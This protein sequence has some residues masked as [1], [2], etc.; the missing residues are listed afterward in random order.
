LAEIDLRHGRD[1]EAWPNF[2]WR[3]GATPEELPRHLAMIAPDDRP[4]SW[5][6]GKIRRRRL[7]LRAERNTME[8]LL[9]APWLADALDDAR[10]V[11]VECDAKVLPLLQAAFP[12]ARITGAG[13]LTPADLIED[14]AQIAASMADLVQAYGGKSASGWLPVDR[15]QAASLRQ[16]VQADRPNDRVIGLAWQPTGSA[17][18]GLEPFVRLLEVPGIRWIA[19]PTGGMT[20]ALSKLLSA[21]NLPLLYESTWT[22]YGLESMAGVLA[23]LDLLISSEDVAATLAGAVGRP[24]WKVAGANAHW[25]W[26]TEG[27]ASKWHPTARVIRAGQTP[28]TLMAELAQFVGA[29]RKESE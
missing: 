5:S 6:G 13:T 11:R 28:E 26:G 4:K 8:Q 20:P 16:R 29:D 2:A 1:E 18:A 14:R 19:L 25:S 21:P 17:L 7:F 22:S 3:F 24:V 9:F 10:A 15:A 27:A 12:K 23:A